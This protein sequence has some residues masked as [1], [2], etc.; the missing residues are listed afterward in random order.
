MPRALLTVLRSPCATCCSVWSLRLCSFD[1][2]CSRWLVHELRRMSFPFLV[3]RTRLTIPLRV[4]SLGTGR[5]LLAGDARRGL[6]AGGQDH[7]QVL[8]LEQRLPLDDG[9][10]ARVIGDPVEDL[11]ADVLVHHLATSEHDRDLHLLACFEELL[12]TLELGLKVMLRHLRAQLHLFQLDDVLLPPLLFFSLD[13]IELEASVVDQAADGRARLRRHLDE[14]ESL[15]VRDAQRSIRGQDAKLV[16][17]VI[18]QTHLRAADLI[19]DSQLLKRDRT[20]PR[21]NSGFC[22]SS[23]RFK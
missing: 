14:I 21:S 11:P 10:R 15:L 2:W 17:L 19:V 6:P 12:Q 23:K 4:L 18:D 5:A 16:V 22:Y 1:F 8:A 20:P 3:A 13:R 7:E 9:E